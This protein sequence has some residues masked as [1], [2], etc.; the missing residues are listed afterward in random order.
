VRTFVNVLTKSAGS[1]SGTEGVLFY[2]WLV[3]F[4]WGVSCRLNLV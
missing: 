4:Q 1:G 3:S 2:T